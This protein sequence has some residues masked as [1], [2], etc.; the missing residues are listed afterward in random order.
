MLRGRTQQCE[1][2]DG[3]LA[4]ARAGRSRVLVVRASRA[5]ASPHPDRST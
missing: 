4:D 2:L 3:L 5:S 1:V